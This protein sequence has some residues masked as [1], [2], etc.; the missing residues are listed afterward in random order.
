MTLIYLQILEVD[1][2]CLMSKRRWLFLTFII[3]L[4][5]IL[6]A[7]MNAGA[8]TVDSASIK[9]GK[10]TGADTFSM[11]GYYDSIS[12]A[13]AE[14]IDF[15]I[16]P[17]SYTIA[18]TEFRTRNNALIYKNN[19]ASGITK[20]VLNE[21]R[22]R[23]KL[24]GRRLD[25]GGLLMMSSSMETA[26][27]AVSLRASGLEECSSLN[28]TRTRKGLKFKGGVDTGCG[29]ASGT[30]IIPATEIS[31]VEENSSIALA[32][33]L[34]RED[35]RISGE[36]GSADVGYWISG[37]GSEYFIR[38]F[39]KLTVTQNIRAT[40]TIA[41]N[42]LEKN[43]LDLVLMDEAGNYIDSSEGSSS[44]EMIEISN[45]GD[46]LVGVTVS[47]GASPYVLS[48]DTA[49][50]QSDIPPGAEFVPGEILV[51]IKTGATSV[52]Q[53][54]VSLS[55]RYG[56]SP[57]T[58]FP[59]SVDLMKLSDETESSSD[60]AGARK[61]LPAGPQQ[62]SLRARTLEMIARLRRD[63]GVEYAEPNFIRRAYG[64]PDDS[65][66][67]YQW[68][69]EL[70]NLPKAWETTTGSDDV[71]V[72][73]IDTGVLLNH[74]DLSSR[75][76]ND[77]YDFI[78]SE[79][80]SNDGDGIDPDPNDP[81][82]DQNKQK[83]SFHGSHVA[84]TIGA[85]TNNAIGV[86]GA[87]WKTK[88]LP[89][90]V[91]GV[92]G[93]TEADIA[94][95]IYYA[96]GLENASG[97]VRGK[98]ADV[99]NM[100]L[101]GSGSSITMQNAI[102]AAR[103]K[104]VIIIAAAGN[105]NSSTP[106]YPAAYAGVVSVSAVDSNAQKASYSNYGGTIDVA[107]PGGN[108]SVDLNNDGK[109]D[110][111]YSTLGNES[112]GTVTFTYGLYQGTSMAAPHVAGVA[113]LMRAVCP[114][115]SPDD[116][117]R[118]LAGTHPKTVRRTTRDIGSPGYDYLYGYGLIDAEQAVAAARDINN[119]GTSGPILSL[120]TTSLNFDYLV[121]RLSLNITNSGSG[122][123]NI[124]NITDNADWLTATPTSGAAPLSVSV[125]VDRTGLADGEYTASI[126]ISSDAD[127][128]SA[129]VN[130]SMRVGE[131][132]MGDVGKVYVLAV[133]ADELVAVKGVETSRDQGYVFEMPSLAP[134]KYFFVA[135]TDRDNDYY[136]CDTGE[137]CGYYPYPVTIEPWMSSTDIDFIVGNLVA[138]QEVA[139]VDNI[140]LP[141][142]IKR[143]H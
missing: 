21:K 25:L 109:P 15:H 52:R 36:A 51:K 7:S 69:Y 95:A 33:Q 94:Q 79:T 106:S 31:E 91:L 81:G 136:I 35:Y 97:I 121:G 128:K 108:K 131:A 72:A 102:S 48:F 110:G 88:I 141:K 112:N 28:F 123:L 118:L 92:G 122:V 34:D 104:G 11:T 85:A 8:L 126:V 32:Q 9:I 100:S 18:T 27:I 29:A 78:S 115:L 16:G 130:V 119:A 47:K 93:G 65:L 129:T 73:V 124:T 114:N 41:A 87:T 135:G 125:V 67:S 103:E 55:E 46:Y 26:P 58:S 142:A 53:N 101:G 20:L 30:L 82:D 62:N 24:T 71:V 13:S 40:L 66:Y 107:A 49:S 143:A 132:G 84:G 63:P 44:T 4:V 5:A 23:F 111:V 96:A 75:L 59:F 6:S 89:L 117:D 80:R 77:G 105:S 139:A 83:S 37:N 43:N 12:A 45:P 70:I 113:A 120:S 134:G 140:F 3:Q 99:I 17:Y 90:R 38:D 133:T 22:R 137:A 2:R 127:V 60:G 1:M 10:F 42:D 116:F 138:L 86:A 68:H 54:R 50:T 57:E 19:R 64:A 14:T 56:I 39:Y 74:P 61:I 98:P 76:T